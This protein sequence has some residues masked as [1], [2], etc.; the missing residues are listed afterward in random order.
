MPLKWSRKEDNVNDHEVKPFSFLEALRDVAREM[1]ES[2]MA[3]PE[4]AAHYAKLE[5]EYNQRLR[6]H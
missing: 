3:D 5:A 1:K 2:S 6:P 4:L